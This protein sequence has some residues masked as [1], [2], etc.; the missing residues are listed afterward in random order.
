MPAQLR[1]QIEPSQSPQHSQ[2]EK[3]IPIFTSLLSSRGFKPSTLRIK[4]QILR[5]FNRWIAKRQLKICGLDEEAIDVFFKEH[6][7]AGFV[8]RGDFSTLRSLLEWLREIQEVQ[9]LLPKVNN[10][11]LSSIE[12]NFSRYLD[13]ERGLSKA[14]LDNYLPVI[15]RFLSECFESDAIV[16]DEIDASD[17]T[18]FVL[19]Y[20]RTMGCR[21]SQLMTSALR[22]FLRFLYLRGDIGTDLALSVPTV[23][24]WKMS[25]L[26][27]Y[28]ESEEVER[29][30][31]SCDQSTA[32]GLRDYAVLILLARLGL[33]SGEVVAL[34]LNDIDWESGLITVR[35]K[36]ARRDQ[37]PIIEDVG[38]ALA[39][40]LHHGRPRCETRRVIIRARAPH[41]GFS[42]SAAIGDIVRRA[43]RRA[44]LDPV[45]KGAH[46]LRHSLATTM[47]QRGASLAEIGQIL[48]HATP[49]TTEIYTKVDLAALSA[50][51]QPW[52]G[53]DL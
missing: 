4:T 31:Q 33:R 51:A 25:D 5:N 3:Y 49:N 45:R 21:S 34:T 48:R 29:L 8:R 16:L 46:L 42:G 36:G 43:L 30:L 17:V 20:A 2:L 44:G 12:C 6:P 18:Q 27:K 28:L 13:E 52:P 15:R 38:K 7:R 53:G 23:A 9:A 35:G 24:D 19:G 14:T 40:Y 1:S 32:V 41:R 37:L 47:L 10:S 39:A 26:P 22:G 50:L 11:V